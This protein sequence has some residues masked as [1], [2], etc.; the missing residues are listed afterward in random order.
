ML[1]DRRKV[2]FWQKIVFGFMA[3]LMAG[4]LIFGY[5]GVLNGCTFFN[6]AKSAADQ[7]NQTI[8]QYID[9]VAADPANADAWT[10]LGDNYVL[11]ANQ[12]TQGSAA[13]KADWQ[14]AVVA[15]QKADK[16]LAKKKKTADVKAQ[17]L[18]VLKQQVSTYLFLQDYQSA[19]TAYGEITSLTP[20]D[21]Q[22]YFD[23]ASVA[24]NAGD[25][26]TALLAFT[27][28]LELDPTSPDAAQV[29]AWIKQNTPKSTATPTPSPSPTK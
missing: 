17:R 8:T 5:S 13:Q 24:I 29:K 28:F 1:L 20:K 23:M 21:A 25:T 12:Q 19:T 9:K 6:S 3:V 11:L 27:K 7:L 22:N 26:N 18:N 4:F 10:R 15:Y 2:K 14:K 16:V